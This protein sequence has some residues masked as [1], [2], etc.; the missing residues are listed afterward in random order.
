MNRFKGWLG[1]AG[2]FLLGMLAGA[3]LSLTLLRR[4]H[5]RNTATP[6]RAAEFFAKRLRSELRLDAE[7]QRQL[8]PIVE[9]TKQQLRDN[10]REIQPRN[11]L[12]WRKAMEKV[13]ALLRADQTA[14]FDDFIQ[15][16]QRLR[17]PRESAP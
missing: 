17:P 16:S 8:A 15:R 6:E 1:V 14:K 9:E 13:R 10:F 12:I 4:M 7:Q 2:I 5:Q 3:A 11:E